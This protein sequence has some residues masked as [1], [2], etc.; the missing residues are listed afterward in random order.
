M[1]RSLRAARLSPEIRYQKIYNHGGHIGMACRR[2][3]KPTSIVCQ[4]PRCQSHEH[5]SLKAT[6][7]ASLQLSTHIIGLTHVA[8]KDVNVEVSLGWCL[9]PRLEK[10]IIGSMSSG[11]ISITRRSAACAVE[12]F[13]PDRDSCRLMMGATG[14]TIW[15]EGGKD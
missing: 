13:R 9:S 4:E 2:M 12:R 7:P 3:R 15:K 1:H 14:F 8:T 6:E 5:C 11:G 10:A